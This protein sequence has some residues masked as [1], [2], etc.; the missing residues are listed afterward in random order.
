LFFAFPLCD[1]PFPATIREVAASRCL[2]NRVS[3]SI[4][5]RGRVEEIA[6]AVAPRQTRPEDPGR[7]ADT[8]ILLVRIAF[9]EKT[10]L[11]LGQRVEVEIA[12]AE[13]DHGGP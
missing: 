5:W 8:R 7:P 9:L 1:E 12:R 10:P 11:K 13:G 4:G 2:D 3:R 6:D